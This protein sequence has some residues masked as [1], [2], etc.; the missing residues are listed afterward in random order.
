MGSATTL[1]NN[2]GEIVDAM[3]GEEDV[4]TYVSIQGIFMAMGRYMS[5]WMSEYLLQKY[6][7]NR[8]SSLMVGYFAIGVSAVYLAWAESL[9]QL[10]YGAGMMGFS[11]GMISVIFLPI[12]NDL[13]GTKKVR[14]DETVLIFPRV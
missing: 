11:Y 4:G 1:L 2:L 3:G 14:T 12:L 13:F 10:G 6:G 9:T 5:G 7:V 8:V